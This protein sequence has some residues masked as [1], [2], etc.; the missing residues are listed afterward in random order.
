MEIR[1]VNLT[2]QVVDLNEMLWFLEVAKYK[3]ASHSVVSDS[4]QRY[5]L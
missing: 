4:S 1:E 5:R 3:I 2:E